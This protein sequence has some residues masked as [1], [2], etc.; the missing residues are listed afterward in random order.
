MI[1]KP[2]LLFLGE[3]KDDLA[4]KTAVGVNFWRPEWCLGQFRFPSA[5]TKLD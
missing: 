1:S 3:A 4:I 2:Y 5:N